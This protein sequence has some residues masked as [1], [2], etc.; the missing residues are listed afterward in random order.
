[1]VGQDD[2]SRLQEVLDFLTNFKL[3]IQYDRC[4]FIGR[5]DTDQNLIDLNLTR[6]QALE[7]ICELTPDDY[8][9]GPEQDDTDTEKSV[10]KFG[11]DHEGNEVY[12]KL[13]LNSTPENELPRGVVWSFHT[14]EHP[15]R[16]PL[17]GG[18]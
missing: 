14:A 8:S 17:R 10:W 6:K 16:Y 7:I 18:A 2:I 4:Q 12:I 1:M 11:Y 15:M 13:R 3:A 5:P 9:S